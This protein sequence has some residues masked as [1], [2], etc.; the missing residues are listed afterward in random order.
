MYHVPHKTLS[1][2]EIH[3]AFLDSLPSLV[4]GISHW[5][6]SNKISIELNLTNSNSNIDAVRLSLKTELSMLYAGVND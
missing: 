3:T 5:T 1:R 4:F 6:K 2:K